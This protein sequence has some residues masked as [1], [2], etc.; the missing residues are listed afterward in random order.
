MLCR[1][2][3]YLAWFGRGRMFWA[4]F[5]SFVYLQGLKNIL[6]SIHLG[7]KGSNLKSKPKQANTKRNRENRG[8][9]HKMY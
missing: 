5:A 2:S 3:W 1:G 9:N 4:S 8:I 7:L 6:L